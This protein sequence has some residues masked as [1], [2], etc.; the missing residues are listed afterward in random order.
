[1]RPSL[2][3]MQMM[4]AAANRVSFGGLVMSQGPA[5]YWR[6][7]DTSG[8]YFTDSSV[9]SKNGFINN[10]AYVSR[11]EPS[12]CGD[13]DYSMEATDARLYVTSQGAGFSLSGG[14]LTLGCIVKINASASGGIILAFSQ[15]GA[16]D[17]GGSRDRVLYLDTSGK[18]RFGIYTGTTTTLTSSSTMNDGT[19]H[20]IHCRCGSNTTQGS[21]LFIDGVQVDTAALI[22]TVSYTGTLVAGL[23]TFTGWPGISG[24]AAMLGYYDEIMY[25]TRAL[26][27]AEILAQAQTAGYA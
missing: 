24:A 13:P 23:N 2:L 15:N 14:N 6:C 5:L 22:P 27:D 10:T 17:P 19:A 16:T 7:S 26:S 18:L 25:F 21:Q 12:L 4:M 8:S 1:M 9:N 3:Q 20:I 11:G